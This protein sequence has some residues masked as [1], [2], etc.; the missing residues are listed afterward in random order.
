MFQQNANK[1]FFE[2][3]SNSRNIIP[4]FH[5]K[6]IS[7]DPLQ[8][9]NQNLARKS[10]NKFYEN[11][12]KLNWLNLFKKILLW[13]NWLEV[14]KSPPSPSPLS[15]LDRVK[16]RFFFNAIIDLLWFSFLY[17]FQMKAAIAV[18]VLSASLTS[19]SVYFIL[20]CNSK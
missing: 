11:K 10:K 19:V 17:S 12:V 14:A 5:K 15:V 8:K 1:W 4:L 13:Y 2:C 9:I 7:C 3:V 6:V 18:F 16:K 20:N